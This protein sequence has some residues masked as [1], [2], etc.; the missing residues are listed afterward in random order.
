VPNPLTFLPRRLHPFGERPSYPA[1]TFQIFDNDVSVPLSMLGGRNGRLDFRVS[2][3]NI[4]PG[5]S[6]ATGIIVDS[7]PDRTLPARKIQ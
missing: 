4:L 6:S 2:S 7:M 1:R 5:A 3:F